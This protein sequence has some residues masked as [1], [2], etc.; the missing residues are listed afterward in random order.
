MKFLLY[1]YRCIRC[2]PNGN[3]EDAKGFVSLSLSLVKSSRENLAVNVKF[4]IVQKSADPR[5]VREF[6]HMKSLEDFKGVSA[7]SQGWG[8]SYF[9]SH[10]VL[11]KQDNLI[12]DNKLTFMCE[13][14]ARLP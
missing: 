10:D 9:I 13:V 6:M 12:V 11:F 14:S 1:C 3:R 4:S 8:F 2:F 5:C 7:N